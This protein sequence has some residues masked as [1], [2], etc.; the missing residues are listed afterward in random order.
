LAFVNTSDKMGIKLGSALP[1]YA[2]P[3]KR[4]IQLGG[5]Y[6]ILIESGIPMKL[7]KVNKIVSK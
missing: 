6:N 1:I 5:R 7:V 2:F 3:R 4:M